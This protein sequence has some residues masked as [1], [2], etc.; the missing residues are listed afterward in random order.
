MRRFHERDPAHPVGPARLRS[1]D[2]GDGLVAEL[3]EML[4]GPTHTS[5]VVGDDAGHLGYAA[6]EQDHRL[7]L[8]EHPDRVAGHSR[9]GQQDALDG[10]E[11]PLGPV[12]FQLGVLLGVREQ[13][14]VARL[15]RRLVGAADDLAVEGVR[16]VGDDDREAAGALPDQPVEHLGAVADV[17]RRG[18]DALSGTRVDPAGTGERPGD[19][20]GSHAGCL[21]NVVDRG[22]A[23]HLL[24]ARCLGNLWQQCWGLGSVKAP[25]GILVEVRQRART[26]SSGP[27]V[28][29]SGGRI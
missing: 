5:G 2:V 24:H 20:R 27:S 1:R 29:G 7:L 15:A 12:A 8:G 6:V 9:A 28:C 21:R 10:A 17:A 16:D 26:R 3:G 11:L 22:A 19:R 13:D 18:E 4:E 14:R 23:L 25:G